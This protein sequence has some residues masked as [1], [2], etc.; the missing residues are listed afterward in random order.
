[1]KM[2]P[3]I[4]PV[5][6]IGI[7]G[8]GMSGIAEVLVN[9]GYTVQG[10]DASENANVQRLREKGV[11]VHIGHAAE[12]LG[13]AEVVVVSTAIKRSNPE[14]SAARERLLPIVRRAEMLAE[15]M[16]FRQAIAIG[17]THGKTTTTSMVATLLDAGGMDPTVVNGGIIN[18]YGTNARMGEG[19]WMVVEADESDGTFLKLPADVAVV[20]NIDPEHLDHYGT[21]DKVRAAFRAFV[22]NVPFYGFAVMCLD[23]PEV[24]TL[25]S[26]IEDR[27]IITYGE[28][29]QADARFQNVRAEG[30]RSTFDVTIRDRIT[31]ATTAM[32][33]LVLPMPGRH[34]VSERHRRRR[35]RPSHRHRRGGHPQGARCLRRRQAAL[36]PYRNGARHRRLRRLRPPPGRDPRRPVGRALGRHGA[37][38]RRRA[39]A[40]LHAPAVSVRRFR[41][42]LQRCRHG[43]PRARLF[44]RRGTDRRRGFG[45]AG[46]APA[47][48]RPSRRPPHRWPGGTRAPHPPR[49]G[50]RRHGRVSRRRQHHGLGLCPAEGTRGAGAQGLSELFAALSDPALALRGKLQAGADLSKIT[51]FRTGGPADLMFQPADEADLAAF[52][53]ALPADVPLTTVGIGSNLLIRDGGVGGVV[54]APAGQGVRRGRGDRRRAHPRGRCGQRQARGGR[55]SRGGLGGFHFLHGIPGSVGGAIR[56]NGGA[57]GVET[58]DRLVE[59]RALDRQGRVHVL[60]KAEM[61]FSY[62]HAEAPDDLIFVSA[63]FEGPESAQDEIRRA[64]DEV[65]HHRET[66]QPVREKTGGSTFKNPPGTSAWKEVDRAGCRG[67]RI[68]GAEMSALH[69]NFM[70]NVGDATGHDLELLG[71][72]VRARVFET[73][74]ILLEWEIKRLGRFS[75][76]AEVRPFAP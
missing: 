54:H 5:H 47:P 67:L 16:R 57:N 14:L 15:L 72:T 65:Q 23:H 4:G 25:V 39:A 26:E 63:V 11:T 9:L 6:F 34:N 52:L 46:R 28:N 10:S 50:G 22:E 31:G 55:G 36:H 45:D 29:L 64:M 43:R 44:G 19:E 56:M 74:G 71:E 60:S 18:A 75:P 59:A 70:L 30:P 51:W 76:G 69:C 13:L 66:V 21:F 61:G 53:A 48:R 58:A 42:L 32:K 41:G 8:I 27:R 38:R 12:N 1:M 7:G 35:G 62:R 3:N 33:D 68:G 40:P 37:R 24:Q 49:G 20:T 17:G 73:S 2:P